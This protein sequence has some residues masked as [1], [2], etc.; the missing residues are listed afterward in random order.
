MSSPFS[1]PQCVT[2]RKGRTVL[3]PRRIRRRRRRQRRTAAAP[4]DPSNR[5]RRR[6]HCW[7]D[8]CLFPFSVEREERKRVRYLHTKIKFFIR[9]GGV[10]LR[11]FLS[12]L[13]RRRG[14]LSLLF[15]TWWL[16]FR[17]LGC[18]TA[19][20][21]GKKSTFEH[22]KNVDREEKEISKNKKTRTNALRPTLSCVLCIFLAYSSF[23][24]RST[25]E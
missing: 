24:L 14:C 19:N 16:K 22:I 10:V 23:I 18:T 17:F 25:T 11:L 20:K 13:E 15:K 1:S 6:H 8:A 5:R 12:F 2:R 3:N 21:Q 9:N 4:A 7:L